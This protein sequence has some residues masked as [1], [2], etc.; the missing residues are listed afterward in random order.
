M[1]DPKR[2]DVEAVANALKHIS[3]RLGSTLYGDSSSI[4]APEFMDIIR[5]NGFVIVPRE[6]TEGMIIAGVRHENMGNMEGRYKAIPTAY[7]E[8]TKE[9]KNGREDSSH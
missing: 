1:T 7:A 2:G 9:R 4:L 3:K 8:E 6:P 5:K